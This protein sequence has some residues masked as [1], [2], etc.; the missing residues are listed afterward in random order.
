VGCI[1]TRQI[2]HNR[3]FRRFAADDDSYATSL[4]PLAIT[5]RR[6]AAICVRA[7]AHPIIAV[8]DDDDTTWEKST[9]RYC[10]LFVAALLFAQDA[11]A[12]TYKAEKLAEGPPADV[13]AEIAS[14]LASEGVKV[15][16][17]GGTVIE[18]WPAKSW[19]VSP[20]FEPSL[21][22]L[23]PFE[24]GQLIGV[25]RYKEK[26]NDF[27]NQEIPQGVYTLR[28][29]LQP[30][31]GSHVGTSDTRDFLL[32]VPAAMD[33]YAAPIVA[34]K[35]FPAS[36]EAAGGT[37]PTMLSLLRVGELAAKLPLVR[38]LPDR[39]LVSLLFAGNAVAG[40]KK[41]PQVIDVVVV[42]HAPE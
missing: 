19:K 27:R 35:L 17:D 12:Q 25:A 7:E 39:E 31:D 15:T 6:F 9:M 21:A 16:K 3:P 1:R 32:L 10:L 29:A 13:A 42:G 22:I 14:Q 34:E 5:F 20:D 23:Y 36:T 37:H 41:M 18:I 8:D 4:A 2:D 11:V 30:I 28:Y 33:K 40:D 26:G 24:M 38:E